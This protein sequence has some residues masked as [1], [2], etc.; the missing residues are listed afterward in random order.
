MFLVK[1]NLLPYLSLHGSFYKIIKYF[2]ILYCSLVYHLTVLISWV[3]QKLAKEVN[4]KF[5][6]P[7]QILSNFE[8]EEWMNLGLR[9]DSQLTL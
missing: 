2:M 5:H 3:S 1:C 8:I 4:K 6:I 7:N 9:E